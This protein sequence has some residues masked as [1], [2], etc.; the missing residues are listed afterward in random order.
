[1][2]LVRI[3]E[4]YGIPCFLDDTKG[5]KSHPLV[6]CIRGLFALAEYD[7]SYESV[8]HYMKNGMTDISFEDADAL[9]NYLLA[10]GIRGYSALSQEF[11]RKPG[12]MSE[13]IFSQAEKARIKLIEETQGFM[14][15]FR[16]K[17]GKVRDYL[18]TLYEYMVQMEYEEKLTKEEKRFEEQGEFVLMKACGQVYGAVISLLEKVVDILGEEEMELSELRR[19]LDAGLDEM[20]LGVIPP[21]IDQV[22]IG[23][24][25]RTRLNQV[26]IV[27]FLGV[28]EGVVPKP[29]K[30]GG[31][32]SDMDREKL[33]GED[34]T[35]APGTRQNTALEQFYLYLNLTKPSDQL[36]L[37]LAKVD[38]E[39]KT[40][41]PSY[42][43]GRLK[44]LFPKLTIKDGMETT[45]H[46]RNYYSMKSSLP[47]IRDGIARWIDGKATEED[48]IFF[49]WLFT[50]EE[51]RKWINRALSGRF[52]T[53][54]ESPL[55]QDIAKAVYG[56]HMEGSVT[57]LE[58]YAGCAFAHFLQYGLMLAERQKFQ[59][60]SADLGQI[61]H[62]CLE[63]F[64]KEAKERPEG[65]RYMEDGDRDHL[66]EECLKRAVEE[67][68]S[69]LFHSSARNEACIDRMERLAKRTVWALQQQ[70]RKGDFEPSEFEWKFQS[71]KDLEAVSLELQNGGTMELRG[72]IDRIDY[73]EEE[74][75][76]YL[77]IIDYKSGVQTFQLEDIYNGLQLQLVVYL[78]AAVEKAR[79]DQA[80]QVVPG[81]IFYFHI[82]DPLVEQKTGVSLEEEMYEE[83]SLSGLAL[84]EKDVV[85]HMDGDGQQSLP[86][87]FLKNGSFSAYSS[88][89]TREQFE[90]LGSYVKKQLVH[91]GNEILSG[92]IA[93]EPYRKDK[94]TAC[95]Y[96]SYRGV[97]GFDP[98][99]SGNQY[100]K[101][102]KLKKDEIWNRVEEGR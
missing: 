54:E 93:I 35:L 45:E 32:L 42:L 63:L 40:I 22:V 72:V 19:I 56:L 1:M 68:G 73:Y 97:C 43:I 28:N 69:I 9:D 95:D 58:S 79:Q 41:R 88:V 89:A 53:N 90:A 36:Y 86:V 91:Y 94:K 39:G 76:L 47:Y 67:Y 7:F 5:M 12:K 96:C 83:F 80:K 8:C 34:F 75:N 100:R 99:F 64:S 51:G 55:S 16:K 31:I 59:I 81:G 102:K 61:L 14:E 49:Q 62:K 2:R 15:M 29:V 23:D 65:L 11:T 87:S 33:T 84:A 3:F 66:V 57:R 52:Y 13:K 70:V 18:T 27:F 26:K 20:E 38:Q 37:T 4:D 21:G 60:R 82:Q 48:Q 44:L 6:E 77:K 101:L 74:E 78:N 17:K 50:R 71:R 24:T 30:G 10:T 92:N 46:K 25:E 85:E 98:S